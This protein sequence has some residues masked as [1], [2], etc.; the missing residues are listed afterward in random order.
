MK[1]PTIFD[2]CARIVRDF[3]RFSSMKIVSMRIEFPS[4]F[5][6]FTIKFR[7]LFWIFVLRFS[8]KNRHNYSEGCNGNFKGLEKLLKKIVHADTLFVNSKYRFTKALVQ[9]NPIQMDIRRMKKDFVTC[10]N[11]SV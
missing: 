5:S 3:Q 9:K 4:I 2:F 7:K 6:C 10:K 8:I 11:G 1:A